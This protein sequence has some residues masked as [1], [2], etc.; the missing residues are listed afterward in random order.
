MPSV[1]I[2]ARIRK[3]VMARYGRA[4]SMHAAL[5]LLLAT[6]SSIPVAMISAFTAQSSLRYAPIAGR[7]SSSRFYS[8][9]SPSSS[10]RRMASTDT[11][12]EGGIVNY[13]AVYVAKSGGV[14]VRSASEMMGTRGGGAR[15]LG[16]PPPR[17]PAGGKFVTVGGVE[18]DATVRP[19]RYTHGI[20]KDDGCGGLGDDD[21][22]DAY[23][24]SF[25]SEGDV[26]TLAWGS[27]G[28]IER[29]VDLLDHRKGAVLTSSYEFPGR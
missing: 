13:N 22:C 15:G 17:R 5:A 3:S 18:I 4:A 28:A 6:T 14:G 23:V 26:G 24:P 7:S 9:A 21:D 12:T 2:I 8:G 1:D 25:F 16:A 10:S 11:T 19:L 29:L 27:D 20:V